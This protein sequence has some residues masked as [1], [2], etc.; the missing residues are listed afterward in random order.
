VR[1]T[2]AGLMDILQNMNTLTADMH[3]K[4]QFEEL[5]TA[6]ERKLAE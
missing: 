2:I 6:V 4:S 3:Q 5:Y 1:G